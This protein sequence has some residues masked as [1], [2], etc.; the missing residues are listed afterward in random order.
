MR[1][2]AG[3]DQE[4]LGGELLLQALQAALVDR[5]DQFVHQGG[6]GG[7]ADLQSLLA[8][9]QAKSQADMGLS[10]SR[11]PERNDVLAPIDKFATSELRRQGLVQRRDHLEVEAV[12]AFGGRELRGLDAPFDHPA[13]ALDQLQ[14]TEPQQVLHM[15]LALGRALP[16]QLGVLALEG[17]QAELL[18]MML[19]QHLRCIAHATAPDIRLM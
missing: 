15:V 8:G 12:E 1:C 7:E 10:R 11:W 2:R 4:V 5:L 9:G 6:G 3:D 14:L 19:Q 17:W 18:E 13:L 16:G